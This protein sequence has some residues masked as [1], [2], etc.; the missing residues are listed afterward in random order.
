MIVRIL[1]EGQ[2]ELSEELLGSLDELDDELNS[3]IGAGDEAAFEKALGRLLA[4]V[5]EAGKPVDVDT[6]VPSDLTV[7]PEGST[8]D[9]VKE[10]LTSEP[11]DTTSVTEGA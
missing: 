8:L 3:A 1:G 9:D 6:L 10:L 7:P 4:R 5:K 2:Y 11:D